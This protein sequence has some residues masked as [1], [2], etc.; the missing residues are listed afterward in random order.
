MGRSSIGGDGTVVITGGNRGL[1]Y[2]CA[3]EILASRR[4]WRVILASRNETEATRGA[5]RIALATGNPNVEVMRLDLASLSSVRR[6][7]R[8][9]AARDDLPPLRAV[10]CNAGLQVVS[11]TTYTEDGFETT[12]GVNHLGH[13]LLVNLLLEQLTAPARIVFVASGTHDPAKR[14]GMPAPRYRS[15]QALAHPEGHPDPSEKDESLGKIGRRRYTTSKLCNVYAAYELDRRL[16]GEG[17]SM[18]QTPITAN[19]FDP[20]LMPGTDLTRDYGPAA[21]F[22]VERAL[23]KL[24]PLIGPLGLNINTVETSG[25]N[26]ARLVLDPQLEG[27]SG[28]YFEGSK[29]IRSS[30]LSYDPRNAAELWDT[31]AALVGLRPDE[32][33][34]RIAVAASEK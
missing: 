11:G 25:K 6:F 29:E 26:L 28:K 23:P 9:L 12:F 5:Q 30:E 3:E 15:A 13:Y 4:S 18:P 10:T 27:I 17:F 14:T 20:G 34:L 22:V 1:G 21:R 31:S 2:R 24:L 33:P 7:A 32:T 8:R 19:A 16:H